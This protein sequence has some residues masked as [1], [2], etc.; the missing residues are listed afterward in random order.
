MTA[1]IAQSSSVSAHASLQLY[2]STAKADGY[3]HMFLRI[4]HGCDGGLPTDTIKVQL[5]ADFQSV[6]PQSK[7]GWKTSVTKNASGQF[8]V[9]WS[10]GALPDD[11]FD[12]FGLSVKYPKKSGTFYVPS[13]QYCG[14]SSVAW[15]ET[16]QA[17]Q[18]PHSLEHPAPSVEVLPADQ[19][20]ATSWTGSMSVVRQGTNR[21]EV[22]ID[23]P[24]T[25]RNKTAVVKITSGSKSKTVLSAKLDSRGD[26]SRVVAMSSSRYS[27]KNGSV[28]AVY[29]AGKLLTSSVFGS[30]STH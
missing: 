30:S 15:I 19:T 21:V 14:S 24:F 7:Y 20:A 13:V 1:V 26:L 8:E 9:S 10:G 28:V 22:L 27:F 29:V 18:D 6:K 2:G 25:L 23:A 16:P 3:G 4:P 12:D 17:G 5:P 11:S